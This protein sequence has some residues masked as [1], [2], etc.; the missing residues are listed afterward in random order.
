MSK[1]TKLHY[2]KEEQV[3]IIQ[4]QFLDFADFYP[5]STAAEQ[6]GAVTKDFTFSMIEQLAKALM[7]ISKGH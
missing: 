3:E 5:D 7:V 6:I 1:V 4:K 2:T